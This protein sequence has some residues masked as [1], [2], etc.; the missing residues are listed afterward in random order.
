MQL[1][2]ATSATFSLRSW[3]PLGKILVLHLVVTAF[4][5]Y[6]SIPSYYRLQRCCS[7]NNI[8]TGICQSFCSGGCLPQCMLGYTF[9]EGTPL[10][11]GTPPGRYTPTPSGRY[12]PPPR[13]VQPP[14]RY[15]PAHNGH[16]SG[17]VRILL[18]FLNCLLLVGWAIHFQNLPT[19]FGTMARSLYNNHTVQQ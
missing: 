5:T 3:G 4:I 17:T 7:K 9:W 13:Q 18:E 8:F 10:W 14:G 11:A 2:F 6:R 16:C 12:T 1:H 19:A 15:T